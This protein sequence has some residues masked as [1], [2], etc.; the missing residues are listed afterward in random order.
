MFASNQREG[1][2]CWSTLP[3]IHNYYDTIKYPVVKWVLKHWTIKQRKLAIFLF[4]DRIDV[5]YTTLGGCLVHTVHKRIRIGKHWIGCLYCICLT[6][7]PQCDSENGHRAKCRC[8][9]DP[10]QPLSPC[11]R[12]RERLITKAW[13]T[14]EFG[15][16]AEPRPQCVRAVQGHRAHWFHY[17]KEQDKSYSSH[18]YVEG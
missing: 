12:H 18:F 9:I 4:L 3:V 13:V 14:S 8:H 6:T 17:T 2:G 1:K 10:F 11:L 15:S 5:V 7:R 16:S